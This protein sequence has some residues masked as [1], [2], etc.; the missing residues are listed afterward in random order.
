MQTRRSCG[1]AV[2]DDWDASPRAQRQQGFWFDRM[3]RGQLQAIA[4]GHCR[5]DQLHFQESQVH[6]NAS[7]WPCSEGKIGNR[8]LLLSETFRVEPVWMLPPCWMA[9]G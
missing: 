7:A 9:M 5:Q 3:G 2:K 1:S 8:R 4:L 6:A